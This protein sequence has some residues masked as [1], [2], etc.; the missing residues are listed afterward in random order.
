MLSTMQDHPL[1]IGAIFRHGRRLHA[2]S[3]VVTCEAEGSRRASFADVGARAE[4]LAAAL[5]RL[6]IRAGDRV[7]TFCWNTQEH[8]EAYLAVPSMGAVLHT[9]NV[10]LFPE[11]LVYVANHAE[12]RVV[13]VDDSLVPLLARVRR[14][15]RTVKHVIVVGRGDA[16]ELGPVLRYEDLIAAEKLGFAWPAV[17]ERQ[18]AAMCYTSGTT[19]N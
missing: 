2:G 4:R 6:G 8:M 17:A 14:E 1:T 10:R 19:G 9:L 3:E 16:G 5:R 7:A 11:Q 18:A 12:D 13:I 15:L